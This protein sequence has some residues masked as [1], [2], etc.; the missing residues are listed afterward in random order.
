MELYSY[1]TK[2]LEVTPSFILFCARN[3]NAG[4]DKF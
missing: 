1:S 4:E 3:L 2:N